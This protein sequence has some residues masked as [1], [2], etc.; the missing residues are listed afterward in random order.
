MAKT[1]ANGFVSI[2]DAVRMKR[3]VSLEVWQ[4]EMLCRRPSVSRAVF[5]GFDRERHV[6]EAA[7]F[8]DP[9]TIS[10]AIDFGF[11]NPFV[12]LWLQSDGHLTHVIDEYVQGQRTIDEHIAELR[13]RPWPA[14]AHIACDPAGSGRNE[15]TGISSVQQLRRAGFV[16]R[17][18]PSRIVEGVEHIRAALRPAAGEPTL[19]IHLRCKHLIRSLTAYHY[20]D[21]LGHASELPV[22]DGEHDHLIDALRYHFVNR[23]KREMES[24]AY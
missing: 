4:S 14:P 24:R 6:S 10:L 2:D 9:T 20:G 17:H 16:V 18:R 19:L 3:R 12:C 1:K 8:A 5:P 22:K 13:A 15:Q 7:S 21:T 23:A 11:A